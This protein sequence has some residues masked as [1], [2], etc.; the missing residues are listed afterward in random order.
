M[1]QAF[2][3]VS[4]AVLLLTGC[5]S[6]KQ[7]IPADAKPRLYVSHEDERYVGDEAAGRQVQYYS[8]SQNRSY[9]IDEDSGKILK[10][11]DQKDFPKT[12][13][14]ADTAMPE[15]TVE[16]AACGAGCGEAACG[17]GCGCDTGCG[18]G[19]AACGS[20]EAACGCGEAA[21]GCGVPCGDGCGCGCG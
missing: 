4:L 15:E 13:I 18:C 8:A 11:F 12:V 21:C 9:V 1:K 14:V 6:T 19:E 3:T 17:A 20:G 7:E 10:T 2:L 16:E 5:R